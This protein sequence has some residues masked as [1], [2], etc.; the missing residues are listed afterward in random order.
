VIDAQREDISVELA[1]LGPRPLMGAGANLAAKRRAKTRYELAGGDREAHQD[2]VVLRDKRELEQMWNGR[3]HGAKRRMAIEWMFAHARRYYTA[4][5]NSRACDVEVLRGSFVRFVRLSDKASGYARTR[6]ARTFVM[7]DPQAPFAKVLEVLDRHD[8][9]VGDRLAPDAELISIGDHF[10]YDHLDPVTAGKEGVLLL[11]W[12][13][14][15]DPAQVRI[16]LG[17]HDAS[18][19]MELAALDDAAF[20][21]ARAFAKQI[22]TGARTA[23]DF[24]AAFPELPPPGVI[25]RD[26]ASF[27]ADQR[28]LVVELLLAGRF[29]L[30]TVGEL[31]GRDVLITHASVTQRE[32]ELLGIP[33]LRDPHAI[34]LALRE[35][36]VAA[37]DRVRGEWERGVIAPLDLSPLHFAGGAGLEGGG[38]LYHRPSNPS[39]GSLFDRARPR[40]FDPRTLPRGLTQVAGHSGHAKCVY[41]LGEW[42]SARAAARKHGGVRTLIVD[43]EDVKYELVTAGEPFTVARG[44]SSAELVMVDG[45]MRRVG[46]D[47]IDLLPLSER[48]A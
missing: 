28:A 35:F 29:M 30:A 32:L 26:Y 36:L 18:R 5:A 9:L 41:E 27:H 19:V 21:A 34:A 14:S 38:L 8:L 11:R 39:V 46:S 3:E 17:N 37:I 20:D 10:D 23:D 1:H 16:I 31:A 33:A 2:L 12:L 15:H 6:M 42:V 24:R 47:E 7:G 44:A 43:G 40:R 48:I 45:E 25:G 13:A 4:R 22:E